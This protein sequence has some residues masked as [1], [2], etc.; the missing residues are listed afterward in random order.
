M[1]G[2]IGGRGADDIWPLHL[3]DLKDDH[4]MGVTYNLLRNIPQVIEYY[5]DSFVFPLTME[6]HHEKISASGQDLGGEMLFG[7]RVGFSGTPSDLLQKN[8]DSVTSMNALMDKF[9]I[10]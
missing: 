7:R 10:I 5:L 4:H 8:W 1:T 6:H 9:L 3:L 2:K